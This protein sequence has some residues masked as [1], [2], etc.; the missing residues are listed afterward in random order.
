M[1]SHTDPCRFSQPD[2]ED[3]ASDPLFT[4]V[5]TKQFNR[6]TYKHFMSL[7]DNFCAKTGGSENVSATERG[8][9]RE[10]LLAI[11]RTAPMQFCHK[12]C[13]A[14]KPSKIPADADG[15]M[16]IVNSIWFELYSRSHGEKDST[17]F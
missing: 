3:E 7:L 11:M 2:K 5:D 9:V 14:Q 4:S 1:M 12:Y 6:P 17:G 15:F 8:E 13:H 10:F 16:E